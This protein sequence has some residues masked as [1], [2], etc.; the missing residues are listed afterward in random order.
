MKRAIAFFVLAVFSVTTFA[1]SVIAGFSHTEPSAKSVALMAINEAQK[2]IYLAAYQYT[3]ADILQAIMAAKKRGVHVEVILD[4]TQKNGDS[5]AAM[6]ASGIPCYIDQTY[7]IMHHKFMVIDG[8]N[9]ETGSFNYTLNADKSNAENAM[10]V[11]G[12][13]QLALAYMNEW[14]RLHQ[15]PRTVPCKG[16]GQ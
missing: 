9:V 13:P 1:A 5:Q 12:I 10:Y 4:R 6:V 16:G 3:S 11:R 2:S 14:V 15:L 8:I 7:K